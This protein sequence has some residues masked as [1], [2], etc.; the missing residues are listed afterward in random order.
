DGLAA[1]GR[2]QPGARVVRNASLR[3][4]LQ[5]GGERL[6]HGLFGEIQISEDAHERRQNPA[7]FRPVKGLNVVAELF[8]HRRRHLRKASKP[9]GSIQLRSG[10]PY[11][12]FI[13]V[14]ISCVSSTSAVLPSHSSTGFWAD[15]RQTG[16]WTTKAWR[17]SLEEFAK[18]VA[19]SRTDS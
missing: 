15:D 10:F 14:A 11:P 17:R 7:R 2:N 6:M 13:S 12:Q 8:G 5:R 1:C 4:G 3:P 16:S 18:A 9:N 19:I